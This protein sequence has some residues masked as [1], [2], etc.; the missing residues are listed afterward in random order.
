MMCYKYAHCR[1]IS[2]ENIYKINEQNTKPTEHTKVQN[3]LKYF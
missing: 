1:S 2:K 3:I